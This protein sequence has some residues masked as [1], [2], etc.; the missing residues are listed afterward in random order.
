[1]VCGA[2]AGLGNSLGL[3]CEVNTVLAPHNHS[4]I[5]DCVPG[6]FISIFK[7][8]RVLQALRGIEGISHVWRG[9]STCL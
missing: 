5:S 8:D 3:L 4:E 2:S 9:V 7:K 6:C 1:M